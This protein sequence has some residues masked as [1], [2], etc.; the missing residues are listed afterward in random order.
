ME[1]ELAGPI[2]LVYIAGT[3]AEAKAAERVLTDHG[4]DYALRLEGFTKESLLSSVF[5]GEYVGLFFFVPRAWHGRSR[6]YLEAEG[7]KDTVALDVE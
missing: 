6:M 4:I 3:M 7:L 5:G 1:S 2:S